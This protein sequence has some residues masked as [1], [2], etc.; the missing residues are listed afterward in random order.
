M[1]RNKWFVHV[2]IS[3]GLRFISIC[4]L[5]TDS[6]GLEMLPVVM[7]EKFLKQWAA[8]KIIPFY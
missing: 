5:F 3:H 4:D 6:L 8:P 1:S 2:R 7:H